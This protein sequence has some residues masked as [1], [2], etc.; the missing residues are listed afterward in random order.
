MPDE[1]TLNPPEFGIRLRQV[2]VQ[3]FRSLADVTVS[4]QP[5]LTVLLG[6]NNSGKTSFLE[7]LGVAFGERHPRVDDLHHTPRTA[8]DRFTIDLTFEPTRGD[9]LPDLIIDHVGLAVQLAPPSAP[10]PA[11]FILRVSGER[12]ETGDEV[13]L[14]RT[15]I[16]TVQGRDEPL[17]APAVSRELM[18]LLG[19]DLLDARRDIVEELR[20]KRSF[21][22]RTLANLR[23]EAPQRES[24]ERGLAAL[25][26]ELVSRSALLA[27][28]QEEL[29]QLSSGLAAGNL[30]V[31]L[32]PL[33][34][35]VDELFRAMDILI[36][37]PE[38]DAFPITLQGMGTRSLAAMLT[39]RAYINLVRAQQEDRRQGLSL[40]A[41]EEPEA[42]LHPQAQR[43]IFG[44]LSGLSGQRIVSTHSSH[45][46]TLAELGSMRVFRRAGGMTQ[47]LR[48][49]PSTLPHEDDREHLRRAIQ[50]DYPEL[51]FARAVVLVEGES[52]FA[53]FPVFAR[54][55]W[56]PRGLDAFG[57]TLVHTDGAG[58]SRHFA[59]LLEALKIPWL[60]FCDGDQAG[61][62]GLAALSH[63]LGRPMSDASPEVVS[64]PTGQTWEGF[65]CADTSRAAAL[66]RAFADDLSDHKSRLHGQRRR[67]GAV[68][69]YQSPG[70]EERLLFDWL[71]S[72]KG[73]MNRVIAEQLLGSP[74]SREA[75]PDQILRLFRKIDTLLG[76]AV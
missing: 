11:H 60:I 74:P 36:T 25:S 14:R 58:N 13:R 46:A 45:I 41:F 53:A 62:D 51:L 32:E 34:R 57:V 43:A 70:W 21:W 26:D 64:L 35:Q 37:S 24:I 6:E 39:F 68:R 44:L 12:A 20:N 55:Y 4:L 59:P 8:A 10:A 69:D 56:P 49:D 71:C 50:D 15:F 73:T 17:A 1:L 33:P 42:H 72:V 54:S 76:R 18:D 16:K 67:G 30:L 2:R 52:E 61:L 47:A 22:G 27:A 23:L 65:L 5:G 9:E 7:A 28:L 3:G 40:A 75:I 38:S 48:Y 29:A 63:A 66:Q 31:Q 19:F